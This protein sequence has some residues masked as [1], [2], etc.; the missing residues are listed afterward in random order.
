MSQ[1]NRL[2]AL[3]LLLFAGACARGTPDGASQSGTG[4]Q[5]VSQ[6]EVPIG[7][8]TQPGSQPLAERTSPFDS[9]RITIGANVAQI[10]YSRPAAKGRTVFG[11][12]VPYD[13]IW[14]TGANEPTILH[15]PFAAEIA[16]LRVE[17]GSYSVYT[18]PGEDS[19]S[20]VINR[21]ISQ[22]GHESTYTPAVQ[23]QEVGRATVASE[24][25]DSHAEQFTIRSEPA[26]GGAVLIME[27]ERTRVRIPVRAVA[28]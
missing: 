18:V 22:W 17:P 8:S 1:T 27:W 14:R 2:A 23:A 15:L 25:M 16:G 28:S 20:I 3:T 7:C 11:G 12:L 21:S 26:D 10:C 6:P 9:T 13:R 24:R 5:T 4:S 19:W